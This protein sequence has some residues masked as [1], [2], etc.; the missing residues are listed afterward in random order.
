[1]NV[2]T[3]L[4]VL[5]EDRRYL[6][7]GRR[8]GLVSQ[9]AAVL[10]DLTASVDALL[11]AGIHLT[12]LFG[13]EHGFGGAAAD[14]L[15]VADAVDARTGLPVFSLYGPVKEPTA[16][17]MADV[18][19]LVFDM[20]DVG[21]RFYTYLSTLYH[22]LRGA[23][24]A[25]RPVI[26]LDRPNPIDG[27]TIEGP[28]VQPGYES[29][30]G[31][32]PIPIRHAMTLGELAR[33]FC[34][35]HTIDVELTVVEM[36]GWRRGQWYDETGLPWAATSP[37][38]PHLS[39]A[40]VYPGMCFLEGTNLSEGRGTALPFEICGA[41]WLDGHGLAQAL[42]GLDL[43]GM[44]FRPV[45][46][47]PS[48]SKHTGL[49]CQGVQVHVTNRQ[50][51]RAVETGLTVISICRAQAPDRFQCLPTSWEGRP[52]HFDLLAGGPALREGLSA[53]RPVVEL[54]AD[55]AVE[56]ASFAEIRQRYMLYG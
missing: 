56:L 45:F 17:M 29:F 33:Y 37:A 50:Q 12:A 36:Q 27:L 52:P 3:G 11:R 26:V 9:P 44:R 48:A 38:M 13:P 40:T 42:N 20:Q 21:V 1:M 53:G 16:A 19:V 10:P 22:L 4:Q 2:K 8:V 24:K 39:T 47:E 28:L 6:V 23:A 46:F 55:W 54:E 5:L 31:V 41:P 34:T 51:L 14:G 49:L 25:G 15:A 43:P 35:E 30:V 32:A 18:D 7:Q